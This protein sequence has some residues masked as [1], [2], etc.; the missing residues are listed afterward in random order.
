MKSLDVLGCPTAIATHRDPS[1]R[2]ARLAQILAWVKSGQ[3][4][5]HVA[6]AYPL[7]ELRAAMLAKWESRS[8]G[9]IVVHPWA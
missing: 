7:R 1:I 3:L 9:G 5:P 6:E 8:V 4:R 2:A